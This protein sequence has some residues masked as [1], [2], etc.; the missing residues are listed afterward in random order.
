MTRA[1]GRVTDPTG[2]PIDALH[3]RAR[4]ETHPAN[5]SDPSPAHRIRSKTMHTTIDNEADALALLHWAVET[6]EVPA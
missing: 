2:S 6:Q 5:P 1:T 3:V 4:V